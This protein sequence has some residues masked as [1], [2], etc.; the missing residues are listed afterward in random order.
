MEIDDLT[1]VI[2]ACA[3][4]LHG[5]RALFSVEESPSAYPDASRFQA[6]IRVR[7]VMVESHRAESYSAAVR[8]LAGDLASRSRQA[9]HVHRDVEFRASLLGV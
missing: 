6:L 5:D 9:L 1:S 2:R 7:G 8:A 3:K 4:Q